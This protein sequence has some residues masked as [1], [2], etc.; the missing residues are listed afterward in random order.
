M[1]GVYIMV[2]EDMI[3]AVLFKKGIERNSSQCMGVKK[4]SKWDQIV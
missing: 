4:M 1:K 3:M 2:E